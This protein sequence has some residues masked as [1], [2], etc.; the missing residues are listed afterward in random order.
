MMRPQPLYLLAL[1]VAL[2]GT[3]ACAENYRSSDDMPMH[4]GMSMGSGMDRE[5]GMNM[6]SDRDMGRYGEGHGMMG[7]H[8]GRGGHGYGHGGRGDGSNL[9]AMAKFKGIHRLG[10]SDDQRKKFRS[11]KHE[12][13]KNLWKLMDKMI[14]VKYNL[15]NLWDADKP[16]PAKVGA[17]Y[18]DMFEL[19]TQAIQLRVAA[20]NKIYDMLTPEQRS[21]FGKGHPGYG[22]HHNRHG[23]GEPRSHM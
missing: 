4:Q 7:G 12:L 20:R 23:S 2:I 6:G 10:L 3:Q 15:R 8:H 18:K 17:A 11:I 1:T 14:D 19:E 21:N 16:D 5:H 22:G 13:K 9:M